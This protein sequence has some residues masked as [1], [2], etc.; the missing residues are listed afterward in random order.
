LWIEDVLSQAGTNEKFIFSMHIPPALLY[1]VS[2]EDFWKEAYA[3]EFLR[4]LHTYQSKIVL[5]MGSHIHQAE[6]RAPA[7][8]TYPGLLIP[9]YLSPSVSPIFFNNP[10]YSVLDLTEPSPVSLIRPSAAYQ[11][12]ALSWRFLQLYEYSVTRMVKPA[13]ITVHPQKLFDLTLTSAESVRGFVDRM[14]T[15]GGLFGR[16]MAAKSGYR[17]LAQEITSILFPLLK[18]LVK[19][20]LMQ[21]YVCA[22]KH[23]DSAQYQACQYVV[24]SNS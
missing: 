17:R 19:P 5:V 2:L 1:F 9:I 16:Y 21:N 20:E 8:T 6:I 24:P 18:D 23:F 13:M 11:S 4:I 14:E 15:D 7:S 22:M 3:S 10:G 12:K